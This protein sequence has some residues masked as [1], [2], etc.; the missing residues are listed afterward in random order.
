MGLS[1]EIEL[2]RALHDFR[3]FVN[4]NATQWRLGAGTHHNPMW[5]RVAELLD[6]YGINDGPGE[7]KKYYQPD[8]AYWNNG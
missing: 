7:G 5:S 8:P 1:N 6:R 4:S 2:A 3:E